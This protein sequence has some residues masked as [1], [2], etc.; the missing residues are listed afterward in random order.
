MIPSNLESN[1]NSE[2]V[3]H[4]TPIAWTSHQPMETILSSSSPFLLSSSSSSCMDPSSP[5]S[6]AKRR[7]VIKKKSLNSNDRPK[8]PACAYNIFFHLARERILQ[9]VANDDDDDVYLKYSYSQADIQRAAL[10]IRC[11][12]KR[13][14]VKLP[15]TIDFH[16]LTHRIST[17]W[18]QLD[19][20]AHEMFQK[21]A[22]IETIEYMKILEVWKQSNINPSTSDD[23][24]YDIVPKPSK[25]LQRAV[26]LTKKTN[27]HYFIA[28]TTTTTK[29]TRRNTT[30]TSIDTNQQVMKTNEEVV[31]S[32]RSKFQHERK[33][34]SSSS[35]CSIHKLIRIE[36]S[37][38]CWDPIDM[39]HLN[40]QNNDIMF[41]DEDMVSFL[42][43]WTDG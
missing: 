1:F 36:S 14:H 42:I 33:P 25:I 31:T 8:R 34:S 24:S 39:Q 4:P 29:T 27:V 21:Q 23:S 3:V 41:I 18:K 5:K 10:A 26:D 35:C 12:T 6:F 22:Q 15:N 37:E 38:G 32:R 11:K 13:K 30:T 19:P 2:E 7:K 28:T 17:A 16:Q 9:N 20:I 43:D 40:D